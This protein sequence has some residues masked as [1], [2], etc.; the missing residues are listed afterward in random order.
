MLVKLPLLATDNCIDLML[1][2]LGIKSTRRSYSTPTKITYTI[3]QPASDAKYKI[4]I[5]RVEENITEVNFPVSIPH[6]SAFQSPNGRVIEIIKD[7][8]KEP[9]FKNDNEK[10]I[11]DACRAIWRKIKITERSLDLGENNNQPNK[12]PPKN[13]G[14]QIQTE[15]SLK[16][17]RK[18]KIDA[19]RNNKPIPSRKAAMDEAGI[20]DKTWKKYDLDLYS[21]WDK[22]EKP[23]EYSE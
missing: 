7:H 20:T 2:K 18:I 15:E 22:R 21:N 6:S 1:D 4:A 9:V 10:K 17:L 23:K 11:Y 12:Q 14:A 13:R 5:Y 19:L 16:T 3:K 8:Y